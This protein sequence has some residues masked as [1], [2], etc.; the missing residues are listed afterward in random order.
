MAIDSAWP[1]IPAS[2]RIVR[3]V[4]VGTGA[5]VGVAAALARS[6]SIGGWSIVGAAAVVVRDMPASARW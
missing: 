5:L 3:W 2:R 1:S 6:C 4:T